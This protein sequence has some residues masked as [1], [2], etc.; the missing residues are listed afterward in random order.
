MLPA[1]VFITGIVI[2]TRV[3]RLHSV[4][5]LASICTTFSAAGAVWHLDGG[6]CVV[7]CRM[8]STFHRAVLVGRHTEATDVESLKT[9]RAVMREVAPLVQQAGCEVVI[10]KRSAAMLGLHDEWEEYDNEAAGRACD[11]AIVVGGD[12]TMLGASQKLTRFGTP[13]IGINQGRLGFI[14]DIAIDEY[15][16][17]LPP[18]LSG[19]YDEDVRSMMLGRVLR[20]GECIYESLALNDVV[21]NRG[22]AAHLV[23]LRAEV[24]GRFVANMRA[25]GLIIATPTGS[26]AYALSAGG[27]LVHPQSPVWVAVPLASHSL[28][29]RP[30]VMADPAEVVI[31]IMGGHSAGASF[32][33][34]SFSNLHIGDRIVIRRADNVTK[35]LHPRGWSFFDMLR[36]KLYWNPRH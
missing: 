11:L 14:T 26:T 6:R 33:M 1:P 2:F 36:K 28:S 27:P 25:D 3:S 9:T 16:K 10:G 4:I 21:V 29:S 31:E 34:F 32:D 17:V 22:S 30:I 18:M 12:G 24:N 13:L 7:I 35:F 23:E 5:Q 15:K 8:A 19:E 20:D